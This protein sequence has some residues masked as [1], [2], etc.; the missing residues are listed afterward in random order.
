MVKIGAFIHLLLLV[1]CCAC[2]KAVAA[3]DLNWPEVSVENR[4]GA[5]W[6]WMGSAVDKENITWNLDAV[7]IVEAFASN[8]AERNS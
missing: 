4:P 5:Y 6:W 8:A 1:L 2:G 7:A 3:S